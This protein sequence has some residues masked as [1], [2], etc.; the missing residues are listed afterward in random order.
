MTQVAGAPAMPASQLTQ[1]PQRR[2][3]QPA[4]T[5]G[6]TA[7]ATGC[8]PPR[9]S[10]EPPRARSH[11]SAPARSAH[12]RTPL[13]NTA[14][15]APYTHSPAAPGGQAQTHVP[16]LQATDFNGRQYAELLAACRTSR[17]SCSR[18]RKTGNAPCGALSSIACEPCWNPDS[19]RRRCAQ[20]LQSPAQATVEE[21]SAAIRSSSGGWLRNSFLA[22]EPAMPKAAIWVGNV[23][24]PWL[25]FRRSSAAIIFCRPA[26]EAPP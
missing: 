23:L 25:S 16:R 15:P 5:A 24:W 13:P 7:P 22:A 18:G 2:A 14:R 4:D 11:R 20:Q 6:T 10:P 8:R 19:C 26:S 17:H 1:L 9:P 21:R 3:N 12:S